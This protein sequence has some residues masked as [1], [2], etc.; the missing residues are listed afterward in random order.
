MVDCI[1]PCGKEFQVYECRVK[2][3]RGKRCSKECQYK[4]AQRPS[5][6]N[7]T[8]HKDNPTSFQPGHIP[9]SKDKI[10]KEEITYKALH[11][12]VAKHR[13]K[14]QTCSHCPASEVYT[15]WANISREYLRDLTDWMELCRACHRKYDSGE[16]RG[17]A[18]AKFGREQVQNG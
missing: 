18:T 11:K 2:A 12:W 15:E 9:W 1:C 8:K 14:T 17:L 4:Y 10:L 5:G 13:S 7:Y 16:F 3:G 6:L